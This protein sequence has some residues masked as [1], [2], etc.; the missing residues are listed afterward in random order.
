MSDHVLHKISV[1]KQAIR[2]ENR[3]ADGTWG[4]MILSPGYAKQVGKDLIDT[5][6]VLEP[7]MPPVSVRPLC[8]CAGPDLNDRVVCDQRSEHRTCALGFH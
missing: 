7:A 6:E 4:Y 1:E 8:D 5:A 3:N 2:M